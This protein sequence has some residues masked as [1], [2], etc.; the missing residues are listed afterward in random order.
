MHRGPPSVEAPVALGVPTSVIAGIGSVEVPESLGEPSSTPACGTVSSSSC[1]GGASSLY[2]RRMRTVGSFAAGLLLPSE[3]RFLLR[4]V[5]VARLSAALVHFPP[6]PM[7]RRQSHPT[8]RQ[9]QAS[10]QGGLCQGT[11]EPCCTTHFSPCGRGLFGSPLHQVGV[12]SYSF[13]RTPEP[14]RPGRRVK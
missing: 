8:T 10:A 13:T 3:R 7:R 14:V 6:L 1:A 12:E 5:P 2:T 11:A 4:R 9:E